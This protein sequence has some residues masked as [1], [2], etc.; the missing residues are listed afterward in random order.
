L[1]T[2][3]LP[4]ASRTGQ[5][6]LLLGVHGEHEDLGALLHG[7]DP[8]GRLHPA[9]AGHGQIHHDDV[10]R[11]LLHLLER[12]LARLRF[13]HHR[14]VRLRIEQRPES[15]A[16]H[17]VII[18]QKDLDRFRHHRPRE[19]CLTCAPSTDRVA[20]PTTVATF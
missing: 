18:S 4:P 14:E 8:A 19:K 16:Q 13:S 3:P 17:A 10:G 15:G 12:L 5:E 6:E 2:N 20:N 7:G 11:E 9:H 1:R